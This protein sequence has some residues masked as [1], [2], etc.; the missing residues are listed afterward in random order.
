[1][2]NSNKNSVYEK[3]HQNYNYLN[4]MMIEEMEIAS[5]HDGL[6][7]DHREQMWINLFRSIIPK[8]FSLSQGVIIIDSKGK[9]SNEVDIAVYDEQYTP[10]VFQYNTLKFIPIEAV[11]V[12]IEC[13][14]KTI[15]EDIEDKLIKWSE[16]IDAL[17]PDPFGIARF[18]TGY[19]CGI[20]NPTQIKTRPIK[21]LA[22]LKS[23][24]RYGS[25]QKFNEKFGEYFDF[26]IKEKE[27]KAAKGIKKF[28]VYLE[29]EGEPLGWWTKRLNIAGEDIKQEERN[30]EILKITNEHV[31]QRKNMFDEEKKIKMTLRDLRIK[32]NAL[33]TLNLQLNQLLMLINNP[34]LFPHFAYA[35]VFNEYIDRENKE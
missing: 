14:S 30:L 32:D 5:K 1:M 20:T 29:N 28:D 35:K 12:V 18:A 3:I 10:Y 31:K 34:M 9:V 25:M 2:E 33:L 15:D 26:V 13:K 7:G 19:T 8:K 4:R 11:A 21:I 16:R 27:D 23:Y 24:A 22:T 6:T 17:E